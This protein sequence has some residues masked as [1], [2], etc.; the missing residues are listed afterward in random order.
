MDWVLEML[1][2]SLLRDRQHLAEDGIIIVVMTLENGS[3][4]SCLQDRILFPEVL[5]MSAALRV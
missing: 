4:S 3:G 1:E 2:I 5:S